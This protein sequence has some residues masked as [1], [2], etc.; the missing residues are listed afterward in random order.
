MD[1]GIAGGGPGGPWPPPGKISLLGRTKMGAWQDRNGILAAQNRNGNLGKGSF[2]NLRKKNS[3][4]MNFYVLPKKNTPKLSY[5][6]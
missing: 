6:S 4:N 5:Y 2:V 1:I 3:K